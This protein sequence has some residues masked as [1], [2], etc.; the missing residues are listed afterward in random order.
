MI[1][2]YR[3]YGHQLFFMTDALLNPVI[4]ELATEVINSET[5]LYYDGFFRIDNLS[6]EK[7]NPLHWRRGGFY[8]ARLGAE[9]GSQHVLDLMDK[10]ITVQQIKTAVTNLAYAGI[11]TT[12][13]W[14]IGYPGETRQDFQQTLDLLEELT[15]D[16]YEA[17]CTP[18]TY[19]YSGQNFSRKWL[20]EKRPVPLFP[21][22]ARDLLI[23]Q[24]W[25]LDAEPSREVTYRRMWR[26][27]RRCNQ[28]G[29]PNPY[30]M[31]D[32]YNADERW[33]HLHA[34]AAPALVEFRDKNGCIDECKTI[35]KLIDA[36]NTVLL[37]D[38]FNF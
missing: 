6:S 11:K 38:A 22:K 16:I 25:A 17:E 18:F 37:D 31:Y 1:G 19:S 3:T 15:D 2:M 36:R 14:V 4:S 27:T 24:T 12:V 5:A 20:R 35:K 33:K 7:E 13:Y 10:K 30:S 8:R 28:L 23:L 26:F 32:I 9:S 34:N 21:G 29:I